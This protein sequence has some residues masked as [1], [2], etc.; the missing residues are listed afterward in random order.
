MLQEFQARN[1]HIK[2]TQGNATL[3]IYSWARNERQKYNID[4]QLYE[5]LHYTSLTELVSQYSLN[6]KQATCSEGVVFLRECVK[7]HDHGVVPTYYPQNHQLAHWVKY[8]HHESRK[9]FTTGTSQVRLDKAMELDELGFYKKKNGFEGA[10]DMI[11][12]SITRPLIMHV[13][14]TGRSSILQMTR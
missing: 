14:N 10:N 5:P 12:F 7:Q 4:P 13:K 6:K 3:L 2:V 11:D 8:L 1:N 9:L